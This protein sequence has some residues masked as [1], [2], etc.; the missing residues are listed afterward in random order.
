MS[1][2]TQASQAGHG[3]AD[4]VIYVPARAWGTRA[5][6]VLLSLLV[7][8][9]LAS[10]AGNANFGWTTVGEYLFDHRIL[11]GLYLTL[12][13]TAVT[14]LIGVVLGTICAIM[15]MSQNIVI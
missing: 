11:K 7:V 2:A 3:P 14:M 9:F 12:W 8:Y 1:T 13:L 5:A 6:A 10:I 4:T 15:T